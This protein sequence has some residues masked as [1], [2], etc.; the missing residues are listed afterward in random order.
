M[1]FGNSARALLAGISGTTLQWYDFILFGYFSSIIAK[2]WFPSAD[3]L[4]SLLHTFGVFAIGY[5]LAPLGGLIFGFIGDRYGRKRALTISIIAMAL[6][7]SLISIIPGYQT[8]GVLAPIIITLLRII[9]GMVASAEF[10]GSTVFLVEHAKPGRKALYGCLTSSGYSSG[11]MLAGL[12]ASFF[13]ASFMPD[14]GWRAGFAVALIG[15]FLIYY[16]RSHVEESPEFSQSHHPQSKIP[17]ITALRK[18]PKLVIAVMGIAGM[19]GIMTFGSYVFAA[20]YIQMYSDIPLGTITLIISGAL[21][22]DA[23]LEPFIAILA[24]KIGFLSVIKTG[25]LTL[26]ILSLPAFY[27]LSSGS[28]PQIIAGMLC[29]SIMIAITYAPLNAYMVTLFPPEY[30]YSGFGVSFN[31]GISL[32]GGTT[33]LFML[34]LLQYTGNFLAPAWYYL[35]GAI[36]GLGSLALCESARQKKSVVSETVLSTR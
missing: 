24:D 32:F 11:L 19:T 36:M 35:F 1:Q 2:T 3:P 29:L 16:L 12:A 31:I 23:L 8:I 34:W 10:A 27:L 22:A 28:I 7:T 17:F 14:W 21:L 9:Q 20:T 30:R 26:F 5:L 13:T 25:I 18:T 15:G 33:P 6:A 4:A